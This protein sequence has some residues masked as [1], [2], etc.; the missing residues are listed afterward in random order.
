MSAG[1][2]RFSRWAATAAQVEPESNHTSIMSFSLE[3][4]LLPHLG[5]ANPAGTRSPAL[6]SNHTLEPCWRNS[7]ATWEMV[8]GVTM[9]SPQLSQ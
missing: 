9:D 6:R 4:W 1:Y 7:S 5:Q 8:S 3:N 2:W